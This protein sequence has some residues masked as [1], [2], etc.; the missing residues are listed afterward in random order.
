MRLHI[1]GHRFLLRRTEHALLGGNPHT[2]TQPARARSLAAGC[3]LAIIV[4]V[5]YGLLGLVHPQA[6]LDGAPIVIGAESGALYVRLGDTLHPVLNLSSARLIAATDAAPRPVRESDIGRAKRGPLLGIP[7][8]PHVLA[9]PLPADESIWTICDTDAP[10]ATTAI[11]GPVQPPATAVRLGP[12]HTVLVSAESG[13]TYLIYGGRRA[14]VNLADPTTMRALNFGGHTPRPISGLL[15]NA[16]PE[17]PPIAVPR[18][19]GAGRPAT[20]PGFTVGSV[21]RVPR[22]GT[23]DYYVVLDGGLQQVG[24]VAADLLRFSDAH[25]GR[26]IISV[27]PDA[28]RSSP[29]VNVLPVSTFPDQSVPL[30]DDA[31]ALCVTWTQPSPQHAEIAMLAGAGLPLPPDREP[32]RLAQ[33]DAGGPALDA[34]YLPPC[35]TAYVR[36]GEVRYLVADTGVR[37]A[38]GDDNTARSL[39][40]SAAAVPAP[41]SVLAALPQGPELSRGNAL[42]ARDVVAVGRTGPRPS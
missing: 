1:S 6:A 8:A 40:L 28:I 37:F 31:T 29:P 18:V 11:V 23:D 33:D 38:V 32:V 36:A 12:E 27:S 7:G 35:R 34:V 22:A 5:G 39:G 25:H 30:S 17:V 3:L 41:W 26:E 42:A 4:L 10:P 2:A 21:V 20:L 24:Q 16:I 15:L 14:V 13:T 9:Q 19:P